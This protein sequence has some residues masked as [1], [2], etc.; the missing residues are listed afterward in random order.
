ML[1]GAKDRHVLLQDAAC[2]LAHA[3]LQL[4]WSVG[5]DVDVFTLPDMKLYLNLGVLAWVFVN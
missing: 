1:I 3:Q 5:V 4:S 2:R